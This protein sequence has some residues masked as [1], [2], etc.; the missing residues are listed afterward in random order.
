[1][2]YQ[3]ALHQQKKELLREKSEIRRMHESPI[4]ANRIL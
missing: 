3:Y 2:G 1:M 4:E